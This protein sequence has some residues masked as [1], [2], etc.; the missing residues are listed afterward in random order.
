M[1]QKKTRKKLTMAEKEA[2]AKAAAKGIKFYSGKK[3]TEEDR[4]AILAMAEEVKNQPKTRF[5]KEAIALWSAQID[6]A[7]FRGDKRGA[8]KLVAF[9]TGPEAVRSMTETELWDT[10]GNCGC[11]GGGGGG[12]AGW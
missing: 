5:S 8:K 2:I 6:F 4:D 9:P 10:N 1:E 7:I 11:G 12:T 3:P